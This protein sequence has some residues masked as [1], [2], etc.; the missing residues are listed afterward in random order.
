MRVAESVWVWGDA[1]GLGRNERRCCCRV[2]GEAIIGRRKE[3]V[4]NWFESAV[5]AR[6]DFMMDGS[7]LTL[8]C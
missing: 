2:S 3:V 6:R 5:V 1:K 7:V 8:S 4:V